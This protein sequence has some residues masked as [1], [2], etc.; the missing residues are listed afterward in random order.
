MLQIAGKQ[1]EPHEVPTI[2]FG[3]NKPL[4]YVLNPKAACT[5]ALNF[6]FFVNH[7]YRYF[8]PIQI[9]YSRRALLQLKAPKFEPRAAYTFYQLSPETFSIVRN[10]LDRFISGFLSK[11]FS[12][13]DPYY[14]PFRDELTSVWG[15]DLSPEADPARSCLAFARWIAAHEN[16]EQIEP[17]FRPQHIN[18]RLNGSFPVDTILRLEDRDGILAFFT[19]WV[20]VNKAK[21]FLSLRFNEH[22][23]YTK[24]QF[25]TDEL[26]RL[27]RQIYARD[28]ELFYG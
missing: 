10:P 3:Q 19:K 1:F 17:H 12:D 5:L 16:Q 18:L 6:V 27:V 13:D 7:E 8:D 24:E 4:S 11:V 22:A 9:H 23:K 15:I 28:Y 26:S 14:V 2:L 21:W 25:L 20:G